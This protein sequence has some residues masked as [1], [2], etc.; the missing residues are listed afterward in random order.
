MEAGGWNVILDES[1][2]FIHDSVDSL[3]LIAYISYGMNAP[4]IAAPDGPDYIAGYRFTAG[5][6]FNTLESFNGRAFGGLGNRATRDQTQLADFIGAGGTFGI[7]NV[8]EPFAFSAATN[9]FLL[10]NFLNRRMS[11]A[12]AAYTSLRALS[13][14]Q[15]VLGDPLAEVQKAVGGLSK[16]TTE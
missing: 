4:S 9:E 14:Q 3:P 2:E 7:G 6:I 10:D 1:K 5:A 12:E 8:W 13:W 16:Q 15:I 11:F